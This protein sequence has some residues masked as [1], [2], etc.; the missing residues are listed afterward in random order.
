[1]E[2]MILPLIGIAGLYMIKKQQKVESYENLP[3]TNIPDVNF[4][5]Q[6]NES[7]LKVLQDINEGI[8][9]ELKQM[10]VDIKQ[11]HSSKW[12]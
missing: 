4:M 2:I 12:I 3:N 1:M 10:M 9:S 11:T 7:M 6:N 8:K 5:I